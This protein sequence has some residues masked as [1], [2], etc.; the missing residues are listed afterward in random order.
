VRFING[1]RN[2]AVEIWRCA[3]WSV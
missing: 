3:Y 2:R 1:A